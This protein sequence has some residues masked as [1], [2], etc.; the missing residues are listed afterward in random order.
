M[1]KSIAA[2]TLLVSALIVSVLNVRNVQVLAQEMDQLELRGNVVLNDYCA[3]HSISDDAIS[4][5]QKCAD[6]RVRERYSDL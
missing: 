5:F 2:R 4:T 6:M 1:A 3:T